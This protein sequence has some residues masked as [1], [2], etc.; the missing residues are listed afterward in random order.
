MLT[1]CMSAVL[2][3]KPGSTRPST[4]CGEFVSKYCESWWSGNAE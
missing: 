3:S 2:G 1:M 4:L